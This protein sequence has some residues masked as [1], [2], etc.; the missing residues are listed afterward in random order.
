MPHPFHTAWTRFLDESRLHLSRP[1]ALMRLSVLGLLTGLLAGAVIVVFRLL[2]EGTQSAMLPGGGAD[3]FEALPLWARFALPFA[4]GIALALMFRFG[5]NGLHLLGIARVLERMAYHQ[6]HL[7]LRG[8]LLQFFGAAI[9]LVSG[10]SVGR[11]GPHVFLGAASGSLLGQ[12]LTLPNNAIRTLVGCGTAAGIA[13]S[14]NT[15]L[16]GVIFS[17]EVIMMEYTLVSFIPVI[18]AAVS[19][20]TI[21]V[22]VFGSDPAFRVPNLD[23]DP[24]LELPAVILLGLLVGS[25][26]AGFTQMLKTTVSGTKNI[27]IWWKTIIAGVIVGTIALVF[28]EVMGIGYD[29][30]NAALLGQLGA[31]TLAL[32]LVAKLLATTASI[33]LGVPGG[34]IGPSL[35]MG[36]LVGSLLGLGLQVLFPDASPNPGAYA[37]LGMGA[38]MGAS[39]QAPLA[40]LTAMLELTHSPETILPGMLVV[41]VAAL[42]SSEAFREQSLFI[43][44]LRSTGLDYDA[45]PVLQALRRAGVGSVMERSFK[46][47]KPV[48]EPDQAQEILKEAPRWLLV[49][50]EAGPSHVLALRELEKYL[51]AQKELPE[52]ERD[53]S[54]DLLAIPGNRYR[55][56]PVHLN[57][58]LQEALDVLKTTGHEALFVERMSAP[59]IRPIY[60][61]LTREMLEASYRY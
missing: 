30:L 39:L 3:N 46:R 41:V 14:F 40:A 61:V 7:N 57:A 49:V 34:T 55:V 31:G 47:C 8:L 24:L 56:S 23:L 26:S 51:L 58:T 16:A 42:T 11:E 2:V 50:G 37:L 15:P 18:L 52:K 17:L 6:G 29:S 22:V 13:A 4:G 59:G 12:G 38:M 9:A 32:L 25:L 27:A 19:A 35:F 36:G 43:T 33:G 5:A 48:M 1:D 28:P 10:H 45:N 60:G 21:S 53:T 54:V 20:T 44:L